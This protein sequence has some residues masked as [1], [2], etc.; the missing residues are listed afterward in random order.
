MTY[1]EKE[2]FEFFPGEIAE[3]LK[4]RGVD[5]IEFKLNYSPDLLKKPINQYLPNIVSELTDNCAD[6]GA[7]KITVSLTDTNL[8][9]E[10]DVVEDDPKNSLRILQKIISSGKIATTKDRE[11]KNK[12]LCTG[13]GRGIAC[14]VLGYLDSFGGILNY[15][16]DNGRIVAEVKWS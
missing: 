14:M 9:V 15:S 11:R 6:K 2:K 12:G 8:K 3:C 7:K 13:G 4:E 1:M 5:V 10:D 16:V